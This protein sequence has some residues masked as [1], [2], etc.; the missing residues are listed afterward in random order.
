MDLVI[1][2]YLEQNLLDRLMMLCVVLVEPANMQYPKKNVIEK[3]TL[4]GFSLT[5]AKREK[6]NFCD[7]LLVE[8]TQIN[9]GILTIMVQMHHFVTHQ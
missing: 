9:S 8:D 5:K 6:L 1:Y 7:H 3:M 2:S 4:L